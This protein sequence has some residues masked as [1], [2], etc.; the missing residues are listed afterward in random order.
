MITFMLSPLLRSLLT[1]GCGSVCVLPSISSTSFWFINSPRPPS[2]PRET[3]GQVSEHLVDEHGKTW[4]TSYRRQFK[5]SFSW[6]GV[7]LDCHDNIIFVGPGCGYS[8]ALPSRWVHGADSNPNGSKWPSAMKHGHV[9]LNTTWKEWPA[10]C[11]TRPE[12][13]H[14]LQEMLQ[15]TTQHKMKE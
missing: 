1:L 6:A 3:A 8:H 12:T 11:Y 13:T 15:E 5:G 2:S 4:K 9:V 10:R 14:G 7:S